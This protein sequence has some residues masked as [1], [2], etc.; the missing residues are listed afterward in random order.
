[1]GDRTYTSISFSGRISYALAEELV[2]ELEGQACSCDEGPEGELT[3]EH[4]KVPHH[5]FY[6]TECNYAQMEGV[7]NFCR[8]H[9]IAYEKTWEAGGD[10][11][12]GTMIFTGTEEIQCGT[13]EGEPALT[14]SQIKELGT[15]F[16]AYFDSLDFSKYP[17]LEIVGEPSEETIN[18]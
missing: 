9:G 8:E 7:E 11:G 2:Q 14:L 17:P 16:L 3:V 6:D 12:P 4:L 15:G 13:I 18:G 10:Y 5:Q 1:M